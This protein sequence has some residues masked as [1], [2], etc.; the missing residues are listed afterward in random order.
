MDTSLMSDVFAHIITFLVFC[1]TIVFAVRFL[2]RQYQLPPG[3]WGLPFVGCLFHLGKRPEKTFNDWVKVYGNLF[4][5]RLGTEL[6]VILNS[7]QAIK[8]AYIKNA[9]TFSARPSNTVNARLS[10]RKGLI[11]APW[12][13]WK[14]VRTLSTKILQDLGISRTSTEQ[15]IYEESEYLLNALRQ[16]N[17]VPTDVSHVLMNAVSNIMCSI[18]FGRRFDYDDQDF[19]DLLLSNHVVM[20]K[21]QGSA[22]L[23]F[24]PILWYAPM[25]FK[26]ELHHHYKKL[27]DDVKTIIKKFRHAS[28]NK[29]LS[30]SFVN[31][32]MTR[33]EEYRNSKP[34]SKYIKQH[35]LGDQEHLHMTVVNLFAAGTHT[36]AIGLLWTILFLCLNQDIQERCFNE[37]KDNI[38]LE[39]APSYSDKQKLPYI[40]AVI[41]EVH[42]RASIVPLGLLHAVSDDVEVYGYTIPKGTMVMSN[43]WA[44]HK[45]EKNWE[46]P[47][48]FD[49]SRFL[50]GHDEIVNSERILPFSIGPRDCVGSQLAKIEFFLF[51]TRLL[52]VFKFQLPDDVRPS[53]DGNPGLVNTPDDFKVIASIRKQKG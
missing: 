48:E 10:N 28:K 30:E 38:G 50:D 49:P 35:F 1:A 24:I 37:I 14:S 39:N 5:V 42:R 12:P 18:V 22:L 29:P 4:S 8:D 2:H 46:R 23:T 44:V 17:G 32:Y 9:S 19:K 53:L 21:L 26:K 45:D 7:Q 25:P 52:Q 6:V 47:E 36:T 15:R 40:E 41:M 27:V 11:D 16:L 51:L 3:P 33:E 31:A 43:L 13:D 34:E 20:T